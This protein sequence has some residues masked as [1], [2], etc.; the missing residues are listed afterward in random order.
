[1]NRHGC[2][3]VSS[4]SSTIA[5]LQQVLLEHDPQETIERCCGG[6]CIATCTGSQR[7]R[8][9]VLDGEPPDVSASRVIEAVRVV[10]SVIPI[11][12]I[13]HDRDGE[14]SFDGVHV[15]GRLDGREALKQLLVQLVVSSV[16][17]SGASRRPIWRERP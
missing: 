6:T 2:V 11:V 12:F 9:V 7:R 4:D 3:A 8:L 5:I 10:D 16:P 13:R 15:I 17:P 1:M 14:R